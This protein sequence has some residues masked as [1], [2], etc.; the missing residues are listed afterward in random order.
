MNE[1]NILRIDSLEN[2]TDLPDGF[3]GIAVDKRGNRFWFLNRK[4]H[5]EDGPAYETTNGHKEWYL[6]G[7]RHREDGPAVEWKDGTKEWWINGKRHREDGPAY[8]GAGGNRQWYKNGLLHRVGGPAIEWAS[9]DKE[10]RLNGERHREDGPAIELENGDK[11]WWLNG[12]RI[13]VKS[14][15]TFDNISLLVELIQAHPGLQTEGPEMVI[16]PVDKL[17]YLKLEVFPKSES[18]GSFLVDAMSD[19]AVE[20]DGEPVMLELRE[21][22]LQEFAEAIIKLG[23]RK[24]AEPFDNEYKEQQQKEKELEVSPPIYTKEGFLNLQRLLF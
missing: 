13:Y 14:Q 18:G 3:T 11:E 7:K 19:G 16:S 6:N 9:G 22:N 5:R 21:D 24:L 1:E 4:L 20:V 15:E 23:M 17:L 12:G 8:I 10:W 2:V